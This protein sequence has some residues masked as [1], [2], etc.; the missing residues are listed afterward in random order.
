[1]ANSTTINADHY[2]LNYTENHV[3]LLYRNSRHVR[4]ASFL[5]CLSPDINPV[6][7][8]DYRLETLEG[9]WKNNR[10]K[11]ARKQ[12]LEKWHKACKSVRYTHESSPFYF[13]F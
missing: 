11:L 6:N 5:S 12:L 4:M 2:I 9:H 10:D 7:I 8:A 3:I 13:W 1:M